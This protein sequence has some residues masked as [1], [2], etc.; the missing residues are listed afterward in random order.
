MRTEN[1]SFTARDNIFVDISRNCT[2]H[3]LINGLS[4]SDAQLIGLNNVVIPNQA[5]KTYL[6]RNI[7][8]FTT[9]DFQIQISYENLENIFSEKD[10]NSPFNNFLNTYLRLF[11]SSFN[12][13][14]R[15][16]S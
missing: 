12:K 2:I 9:A 1:E 3:P 7:N 10:V 8:R 14:N 4:D 11:D 6:I 15:K 16:E 13:K 5:S